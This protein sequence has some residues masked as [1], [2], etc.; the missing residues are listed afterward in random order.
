MSS[1][2]EKLKPKDLDALIF[3][4]DGVIT[5]TRELHKK[6]WRRLFDGFFEETKGEA[7]MSS[8]DY[9]AYIDGK[10]RYDGIKSFLSS[11]GIELPFGSE[12]DK[13]GNDTI[14][15]LGN[16]KNRIFNDLIKE[17]GVKV[18]DGAVKRIEQWRGKGIKT[19]IVSSSK[20]C[21]TIIEQAGI[22]ALFDVRVDG[23]VSA[24]RNL[25]GKPDPD[26]FLEAAR[27]LG[28]RP[29]RSIVFEDA[30]SGVQAGQNG[31]FG[32]VVGLARFDNKEELLDHGADL[33]IPDFDEF[34]L[35]DDEEIAGYFRYTK[36]MVFSEDADVFERLTEKTPV[37]FLDYDGTLTPIVQHPEDAVISDEMRDSLS[38]LARLFTV[39]VVTGRDKEDVRDFIRLDHLIYSGSHGYVTSGPNGLYMEHEQSEEIIETMDKVERDLNDLLDEQAEG[40]QIDRKRF[41]IAIH[42][43]NAHEKDVPYVHQVAEKMI[44]KYEGLKSGEGKMVVE[45]RPDI[46]WHKGKAVLWIYETL[47]LAEK[48]GY[49]PVFIGDDVTDE[50]AFKALK[51]KGLGILVENRGQDTAAEYSLKNVF[52]VRQFFKK[53]IALNKKSKNNER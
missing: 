36:P 11:R 29:E 46:D 25:K 10:P 21:K 39:A 28:A 5:Q 49:V 14:C 48:P 50:D 13:P 35:F 24:D 7:S 8:D 47:G 18:Y 43:R 1:S 45:I 26:I 23:L 30:I 20:N 19:A 32:L 38:E 37:F 4:L 22:S 31:F 44:K 40:V 51:G 16:K 33:C 53:I 3:D 2:R 42:Y 6:A 12:G 34:D 17:E 9:D 15:A 27:E 52:Q 41:A